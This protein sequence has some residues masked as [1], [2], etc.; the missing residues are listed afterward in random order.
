[1]KQKRLW[2]IV[3]CLLLAALLAGFIWWHLPTTFLKDVDPAQVARIE[4]F[5]GTAGERF[6]IEDPADIEYIVRK[7]GD[8][9]MRKAEWS[10]VDGFVYSLSVYGTDGRK[11]DSF[12][13]NGSDSI[14]DGDIRY[15]AVLETDEDALCFRFIKGLQEAQQN[16]KTQ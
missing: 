3:A 10:Q 9:R 2:I 7:I 16:H 11:L 6:V 12:I 14:R 1:M 5:D 8:V 15:E 13:L 4:V